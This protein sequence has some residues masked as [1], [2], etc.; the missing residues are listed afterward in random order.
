MNGPVAG[1]PE[2]GADQAGTR[3]SPLTQITPENVE[4]LEVAWIHRTGDM[5]DGSNGLAKSSFQAT[6]ILFEG[7][8]FLCTPFNRVLALDPTD[9]RER[10]SFDPK[11]DPSE[12]P[13]LVCRG[14]AAWRD[15]QAPRE[16]TCAARIF[17]ATV[18]ARLFALDARTGR[19][20]AGFG[21]A[22]S[23]DL[24]RGVDVRHPWEYGVTSP[25]L[26]V[27]GRVV[28]GAMVADNQRV[29][30]P[31][32][33][34]RAF[35][36]RTGE[37][38]WAWNSGVS[39]EAEAERP[40]EGYA[41]GT[42]NVWSLLSADEERGL[43][44]AP[45]G[46]ASPDYFAAVRG[47]RGELAS[48]VVA[49]G[50]RTGRPVWSFQTVH[51][52]VWDYDV[53]SQP[54]LVELG[55]GAERVPALVQST[56]QGLLFVLDRETGRPHFAV[57]ERRVPQGGAPGER[58]SPT[59]PVPVRPPPLHP[60]GLRPEDAWGFT[61]WD[62]GHCRRLI[63]ASR[64]EGMFTPPSL[65]GSIHFPGSG[66]A[67]NWG[68]VAV[69]PERRW[70]V[71]NT[72]RVASRV[73]LIPRDEW[74]PALQRQDP[75]AYGPQEGTPY[76]VERK[77]LLSPLGAPCNPPPWGTLAA[78]DLEAG[79]ILWEVPLGTTRDLAPWPFWWKAGVP[80]LGGPIVTGSGL[81]FIGAA[82]DDYLRAFDLETGEELWR[83]RLPAGGQA[84]PMTYRLAPDGLQYVVL[85]AGG[86]AQLGTTP[87]DAVVAFALPMPRERGGDRV[88][89]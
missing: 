39:T 52:D 25:P 59:Q 87:G 3:Y 70:L 38:A 55:R 28:V 36:A 4:H 61:P 88:S 18:D 46:N 45:T 62:R 89:R 34:V 56:K 66:G 54:T 78:V 7:S 5:A 13:M 53:P 33:V 58:L 37:L 49:L 2:V 21:A 71:V 65:Q 82:T 9:G 85:A 67:M 84:T 42:P 35:D 27:G 31:A 51:A 64:S 60:Q 20:C 16:A 80:N 50:A 15:P 23:V 19:P 8:L 12:H 40:E 24:R 47:E 76:A 32:G 69:H 29:R 10:W 43:V 81:V 11:L 22:G 14:V 1:W 68:G 30:A 26:V 77:T 73:R 41:S 57:E 44:F 17:S 75:F 74:D 86:H 6:P 79:E 83:G 72:M 48:A 63:E